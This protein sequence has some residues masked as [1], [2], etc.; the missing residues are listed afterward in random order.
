M[1]FAV[2]FANQQVTR[3]VTRWL[4]CA[5][6]RRDHVQKLVLSDIIGL[7]PPGHQYA[8][9]SA[10]MPLCQATSAEIYPIYRAVLI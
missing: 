9:R 3:V 2:R 1:V 7:L 8:T 4:F 5:N 10:A 6:S